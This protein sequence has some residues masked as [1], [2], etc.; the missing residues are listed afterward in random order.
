M[1]RPR[2][3]NPAVHEMAWHAFCTTWIRPPGGLTACQGSLWPLTLSILV[4]TS[5]PLAPGTHSYTEAKCT[6]RLR[7]MLYWG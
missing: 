4:Q 7:L 2:S 5:M 3:G 6:L 1:P